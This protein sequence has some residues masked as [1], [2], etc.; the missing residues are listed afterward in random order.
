[1]AG[2]TGFRPSRRRTDETAE[3]GAPAASE[4]DL[5]NAALAMLARRDFARQDM[6]QRLLKR[7]GDAAPIAP[8]LDWLEAQQLL[9]DGRYARLFVRSRVA[10]GQGP[11][12]IRQ[13]LQ[14]AG[15]SGPLA[16][17]A[18]AEAEC[19]WFELAAVTCQKRFGA[20]PPADLKD[21]ARRLRFLQYRG[22]TG[23]QCFAALDGT[24]L[25]DASAYEAGQDFD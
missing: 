25:D 21:K 12:R 15:I 4:A 2:R 18:L 9:D 24:A 13:A 14:Q 3:A 16:E 6:A 5:R 11:I 17:Q 19:D 20:G 10:R 8:L 1:M 22:F 23:D 7:F